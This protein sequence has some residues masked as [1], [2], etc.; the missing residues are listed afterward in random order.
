[1]GYKLE[2]STDNAEIA[3]LK[4]CGPVDL[5]ADQLVGADGAKVGDARKNAPLRVAAKKALID[6]LRFGPVPSDKAMEQAKLASGAKEGT[7]N[8]ASIELGVLK[9]PHYSRTGTGVELWTWELPPEISRKL[10]N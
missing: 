9:V 1:M 7:V 6:I 8:K 3:V 10:G 4:W 5:T 2:P